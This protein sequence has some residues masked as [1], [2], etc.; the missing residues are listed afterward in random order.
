MGINH[1]HRSWLAFAVEPTQAAV[2]EDWDGDGF[3]LDHLEADPGVIAQSLVDDMTLETSVWDERLALKGIRNQDGLKIKLNWHG[4][5]SVTAA[6]DAVAQTPL[7]R[8]TEH[9]WGGQ[10]RTESTTCTGGTALIPTLTSVDTISPG[11]FIGFEDF[12]DPGRVHIRR[13]L[14]VNTLSVTLDQALPFTPANGD[15]AHGTSAT[16][17]DEEAIED[18]T[19][20]NKTL[21]WRIERSG[22]EAVYEFRGTASNLAI[23]V[24]RNAPPSLEL[25][26]MAGN[27]AHEGLTKESWTQTPSG[28]APLVCGRD[29]KLFLQVYG[30]HT[31]T[32]LHTSAVAVETGV[33]RTP[34]DSMVEVDAGMEGR[35]GYCVG[36]GKT[37]L[38]VTLVPQTKA[39]EV[40]LQANTIYKARY[41]QVAQAGKAWAVH[42]SRLEIAETPKFGPASDAQAT[43]VKFKAHPDLTNSDASNQKLWRSKIILVQA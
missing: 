40:A 25:S 15:K 4:T 9:C 7:M 38:S 10:V 11:V 21:A 2:I 27:F 31:S 35:T 6:G 3:L 37:F 14:A 22:S 24:G 36:R 42:F 12:G 34:I 5:G 13:V 19:T 17:L 43:S 1:L 28:Q 23:N 16:Y 20:G 29:T 26:V 8:V 33:N 41:A 39:W 30:T 32:D 18:T